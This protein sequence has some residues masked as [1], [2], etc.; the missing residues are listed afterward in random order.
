VIEPF[1]TK[2]I[3]SVQFSPILRLPLLETHPVIETEIVNIVEIAPKAFE[4]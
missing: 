2:E 1:L 4:Q 3:V